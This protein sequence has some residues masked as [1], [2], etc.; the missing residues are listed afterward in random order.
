VIGVYALCM[1]VCMYCVLLT[2]YLTCVCAL[3]LL[4]SNNAEKEDKVE[5][6]SFMDSPTGSRDGCTCRSPVVEN[7][8][9][10]YNN[11]G[12]VGVALSVPSVEHNLKA[13]N[14]KSTKLGNA[15]ARPC[16][17]FFLKKKDTTKRRSTRIA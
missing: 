15:A 14:Q 5:E 3:F 17:S 9:D 2:V 1:Y 7:P 6:I 13:S 4:D 12:I 8:E 11:E 10:D 16:S